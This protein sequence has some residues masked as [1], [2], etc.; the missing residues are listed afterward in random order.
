M[1]HS[2]CHS[3]HE[4]A[5]LSEDMMLLLSQG[6]GPLWVCCNH[7]LHSMHLNKTKEQSIEQGTIADTYCQSFIDPAYIHSMLQ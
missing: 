1:F 5:P 7:G 2:L 4:Y 6:G 3:Q